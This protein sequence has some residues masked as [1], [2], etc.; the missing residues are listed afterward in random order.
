[1]GDGPA[2]SAFARDV[3]S[4]TATPRE[5]IGAGATDV[6][7]QRRSETGDAHAA[8]TPD[9]RIHDAER[10]RGEQPVRERLRLDVAVRIE[11]APKTAA[12]EIVKVGAEIGEV[13]V[14]GHA[15]LEASDLGELY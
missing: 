15:V 9:T 10:A 4:R 1:T 7:D 14:V 2:Q 12:A 13:V 3:R 8:R 11:R 5:A 6:G